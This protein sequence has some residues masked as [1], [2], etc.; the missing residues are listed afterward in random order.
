[1]T[2][3]A[4]DLTAEHL[5]TEQI[6][7]TIRN[8]TLA[9]E[10]SVVRELMAKADISIEERD[11]I[12]QNAAELIRQVRSSS[13]PTM[14]EKFLGEYG[15][16]TKEGVALMCMAEALLRVPDSTTIDALI[17]D[18]ITSG[19]WNDHLGESRSSLVNMSTWALL[20]TGKLVETDNRDGLIKTLRGMV[21]RMGEPVIRTA[22][23]QAMK[24]LGR[25]FVLG[26][27]IEEALKNAKKYESSG[28]VYSYDMLGEGAKNDEDALKYH[29]AYSKAIS[30]LT[31]ACT[32]DDTRSNPGISVKLSAIHPRYEYGQRE[33]VM[34]EL[35][36]RTLE[37][38]QQ[39]K[40]GNMGFNIDAEEADRLDL[41]LDVIEAVLADPSLEGWNG[42]GIVVQAY[43][44]RASHVL[45]WLY[46]LT[47]KLDR[48]IM[49]RLVKGAYWDAEVKRAQIMGLEGFP[50]FTRKVNSDVSY[51]ACAKQL[52]AMS[53]RIYA[54]FA[55]HNAHS[56][57]S[58]LQLA[59]GNDNFEFQRLHG[60]GESLHEAVF[61][62]GET[63]CRIY[64]PVG[65]HE[66]LLAYLVRRL[67]ENG[68]NSSFVN[69]IVDT[70]IN[71]EDI[72]RDPFTV[73]ESFGN[74]IASQILTRPADLYGSE[75]RNSKG[76]DITDPMEVNRLEEA[77]S[78][79]KN[80][81]W[82]A[83]PVIA[84]EVSSSDIR[85]V[86]NPALPGDIVGQVTQASSA[87]IE[88]A[89]TQAGEEYKKWSALTADERGICIRR[90]ADL[91]EEHA[92]ELFV[93]ATREAGKT[94]L[95]A[96]AEIREAV[97]FALYYPNE[98][99][100]LERSAHAR[101]IIACISPWNFPLAIFAGQVL[102]SLAAG[103][104]VIAKPAGQTALIANRAVELMHEAGIPK[105]AIQLLPGSG[106]T[107]GA[108]LTSDP[109]IA[110]VCFT[111]ST[112]TALR[113]NKVM[114]K[115]MAPD[116]PLVAET[117]GLNAMIVDST[118]LPEQVVRD[119]VAS[120][121]QSAGQRCSA[122]RML[123]V[124]KDIADNLLNML[125]GAMDE[126]IVGDPWLLSTDVGPVIDDAAKKGIETHCRKFD[127]K[128][129]V[130]KS[131]AI[132]EEGR[133]VAPTII[134]LD[135]IEELEEE[136]FGPV[137]HVAT[138]EA[139]E[140]DKVVDTINAQGF[141]LT[142]GL[143]TRVDSRV[144]QI[145]ERIKAGNIYVNRNQIGAIVGSQPFGGEGLSGTGPKAGGPHYVRRFM[146][147]RDN[148]SVTQGK[149]TVMAAELQSSINPLDNSQWADT[150]NRATLL[151]EVLGNIVLEEIAT[152]H[153]EPH[154]MPGP[155]GENN[156]LTNHAR[157]V[158]LCLG[159]DLDT[160]RQQAAASLVQG[161]AAL[162]VAP[163]VSDTVTKLQ[164]KGVPVQGI[165]GLLSP[166]ALIGARGFD[167]IVSSADT[168]TLASYRQALA[169]REGVLIPL[170][171]EIDSP[172]RFVIERHLCVDTTA[173]GGN[174]SLIAM[175]E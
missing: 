171:T 111:G 6:R 172:E 115:N 71:P 90:F 64:A 84:G 62:R 55:T 13:T 39:A 109:R 53:D 5:S 63:R 102:A 10:A 59:Q 18:K 93:L 76:W 35:V 168:N 40:A 89:I 1:M 38:A 132:P 9:D 119:V 91:M 17:E 175:S 110:G 37:L 107:V 16:S 51:M 66:D 85:T 141:G 82:Q 69:Q 46:A 166:D 78:R 30:G 156:L 36:P 86:I 142:F 164:E 94:M 135:G 47:K 45:D 161:N 138:F 77:R 81:Q 48:K 24:E 29:E 173:A 117:G 131:L 162:L 169:E 54:Q 103:N 136:I 133:F 7:Q 146:A 137:L 145:V 129:R 12:C 52:L 11:T 113:I 114:A 49:V 151:R 75:R 19:N 68:A 116:A 61:S 140:I 58:I 127:A 60:M 105:A 112:A 57:S 128:G 148:A 28:Y 74:K 25:Q 44:P 21:K 143:H 15:L 32:S 144:S 88:T 80:I 41:S 120:A 65:A 14:M 8:Y 165:D 150:E 160:V 50:V 73:V 122:L 149:P 31:P 158:V 157:G 159:P 2:Q 99:K 118:A 95:D 134:K 3:Q 101:G 26:R 67:L 123:Y 87:D 79:F 98:A 20:I 100:R 22:V 125:Y 70:S 23:A 174:A 121:F 139:D 130:L 42:F 92:N 104:V 147:S 153:E 155:T 43:G 167:A 97:D 27:N 170:I 4:N 163:G 96:V 124:Q 108:A 83:G 106:S 72:A 56:V 154:E 126:L 34:A 33:R 152:G